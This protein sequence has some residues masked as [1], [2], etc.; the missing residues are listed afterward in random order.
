M[1]SAQALVKTFGRF[2]ALDGL[3]LDQVALARERRGGRTSAG[4]HHDRGVL[5]TAALSPYPRG[6]WPP[7]AR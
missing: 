5:D 6:Q 4:N 1:I 2:R 3:Q 7:S